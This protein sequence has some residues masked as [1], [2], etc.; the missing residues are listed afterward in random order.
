[1]GIG[2]PIVAARMWRHA[3][4]LLPLVLLWIVNFAIHLDAL[5]ALSGWQRRGSLV[6]VDLVV[7]VILVIAGRVFPMFTRNATRMPSIR[8]VPVLDALTIGSMAVLALLDTF[9]EEPKITACVAGVTGASAAARC[10]HWGARHSLRIPLLWILHVGYAWIP[11]GLALRAAA[12]FDG[13]IPAVLG[14]HA[15]TI[16]AIGSLTLGMMSRVALGHTA[17]PLVAKKA[18]TYAFATVTIAAVVRVFVP[19]LHVAWYQASVFTSGILW[20]V[21]FGL[22]LIVYAPILIS[23][24]ADGRPG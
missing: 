16:G 11:A 7:L 8:S 19:L 23:Q 22:F 9:L 18:V 3:P 6:A 24:R 20:T 12:A 4:M 2:R 5:G 14:T 15:L 10:V 1:V 21:A 17:R 13:R